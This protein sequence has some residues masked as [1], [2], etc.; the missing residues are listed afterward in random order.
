MKLRS[1]LSAALILAILTPISAV[2]QS[3][4][5]ERQQQLSTRMQA[6]RERLAQRQTE[7]QKLSREQRDQ[8]LAELRDRVAKHRSNLRP[9]ISDRGFSLRERAKLRRDILK[10]IRKSMR[11]YRG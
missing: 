1:I 6:L 4:N 9:G 5:T 8:R 10:S 2:A 7:R 3:R 11:K